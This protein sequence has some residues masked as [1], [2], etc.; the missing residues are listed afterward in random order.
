M[1]L[2]NLNHLLVSFDEEGH[3]EI[4]QLMFNGHGIKFKVFIWY[5]CFDYTKDAKYA[6]VWVEVPNIAWG[7]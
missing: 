1:G 7:S 4:A 3:V 6:L 2:L 5:P